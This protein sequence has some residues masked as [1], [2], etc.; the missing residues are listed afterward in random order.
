MFERFAPSTRSAV[1]SGLAEARLAGD[2]RIGTD[3]LLLG[4]LHDPRVAEALATDA[5]AA[6]AARSALDN[7][8]LAA[9]GIDAGTFRAPSLRA[10]ITRAPFTSGSRTVLSRTL[11]HTVTEHARAIQPKHLLMALLEREQPDPAAALLAELGVDRSTAHR[12]A[13]TL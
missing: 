4:M 8:A 13:E 2:R 11:E 12:R 1:E 10:G 3:H 5:A 9:V 6:R 7:R